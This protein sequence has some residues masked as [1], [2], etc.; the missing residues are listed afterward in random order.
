M[1]AAEFNAA[2]GQLGWTVADLCRELS[3]AAPAR[4]AVRHKVI[5]RYANG[6]RLVPAGLAAYLRLACHNDRIGAPSRVSDLE[7]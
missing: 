4:P 1:T 2:L 7:S 6:V 5:S 3:A